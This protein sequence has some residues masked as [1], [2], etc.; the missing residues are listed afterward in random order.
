[1]AVSN[2]LQSDINISDWCYKEGTSLNIVKTKIISRSRTL[3]PSF[4]EVT[5]NGIVL[6]ETAEFIIFEV[7]FEQQ[8][9]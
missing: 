1:M 5:L 7:A 3:L 9:S 4:P 6:K 8:R 2:S